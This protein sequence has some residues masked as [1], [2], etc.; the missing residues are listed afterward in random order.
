VKNFQEHLQSILLTDSLTPVLEQLHPDQCYCIGQD[1][2][3]YWRETEPPEQG[4][5]CPDWFYVPH[6]PP[7]LDGKMRRSYVIWR[8]HIAP[9]IVLEL[10]SGSG[11]EHDRTP[12]KGKFW[13][14]EQIIRVPYYGIYDANRIQLEVFEL[15]GGVYRPLAT[16]KRDHYYLPPLGI[17]LGIWAGTYQNQ[18]EN[19]LRWWDSAGNLLLIGHE[20]AEQAESRADRLAEQL[21]ALGVEPISE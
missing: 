14:Y 12:L 11:E 18:P 5:V 21:R 17:E 15:S 10:V 6:V 13:V 20:R 9:A 4:A 16:N 19:W 1:C 7:K 8:E 2:G 3:I